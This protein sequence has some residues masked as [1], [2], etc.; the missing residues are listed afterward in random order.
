[1]RPVLVH[2]GG[3]AITR[4]MQESGLKAKFVKGLRVTDDDA[5]RVVEQVL[6]QDVNKELV[7][8]LIGFNCRAKG[9]R[10]NDII[11]VRKHTEID[12]DTG[13]R[14]DWGHVGDVLDVDVEE[15]QRQVEYARLFLLG[16]REELLGE[17]VRHEAGTS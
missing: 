11:R 7:E 8:I 10:G 5:I 2:G 17:L 12:P 3:K 15:Y 13:E 9:V 6:N 16:R 4:R 1:M 14:I